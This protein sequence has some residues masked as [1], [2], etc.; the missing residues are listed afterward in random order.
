MNG[1]G[2]AEG[3]RRSLAGS[4]ANVAQRKHPKDAQLSQQ[5]RGEYRFS[6]EG[7]GKGAGEGLLDLIERP[8][9]FSHSF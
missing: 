3:A 2:K 4:Q 7:P 8:Q 1:K 9:E 6:N 5:Q